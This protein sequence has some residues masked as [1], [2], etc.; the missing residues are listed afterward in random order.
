MQLIGNIL[1]FPTEIDPL[2]MLFFFFVEVY[3]LSKIYHW[4]IEICW[5]KID[6][7]SL[8]CLA[9]WLTAL[10][11][12]ILSV[13]LLLK[14]FCSSMAILRSIKKFFIGLQQLQYTF[15]LLWVVLYFVDTFRHRSRKMACRFPGFSTVLMTSFGTTNFELQFRGK[16]LRMQTRKSHSRVSIAGREFED[17]G[18]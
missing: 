17:Y 5:T 16:R 12:L 6:T 18:S 9:A 15:A 14:R 1:F 8:N 10:A 2:Y 3:P 13:I 7:R 11:V 4:S